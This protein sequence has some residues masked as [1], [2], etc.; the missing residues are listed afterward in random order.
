MNDNYESLSFPTLSD[1]QLIIQFSA[2][3]KMASMHNLNNLI[4]REL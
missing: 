4:S 1:L 3:N 2:N